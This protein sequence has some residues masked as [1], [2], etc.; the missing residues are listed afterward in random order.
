VYHQVESFNN[1]YDLNLEPKDIHNFIASQNPNKAATQAEILWEE[2]RKANIKDS[3]SIKL[4]I[5][6]NNE[7]EC[8]FIQT[9]FMRNW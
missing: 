1:E 4:K 8:I 5:N 2:L 6:T 9:N 7:L 3:N